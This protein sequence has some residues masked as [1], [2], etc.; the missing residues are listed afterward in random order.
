MHSILYPLSD[1]WA[2]SFQMDLNVRALKIME[3]IS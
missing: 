3:K 1:P 2:E